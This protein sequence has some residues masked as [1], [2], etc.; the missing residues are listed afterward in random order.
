MGFRYKH[1][2]VQV[3]RDLYDEFSSIVPWGMRVLLVKS[4]LTLILNAARRTDN[5]DAILGAII[6]GDYQLTLQRSQNE[7]EP[8]K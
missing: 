2:N 7:Q 4:I 8:S 6:A 5:K 1:I 3:P